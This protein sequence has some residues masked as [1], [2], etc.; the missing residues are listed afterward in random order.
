MNRTNTR[1]AIIG[2]GRAG[3]SL[4]TMIQTDP[5]QFGLTVVAVA[6]PDQ[7]SPGV[8]LARESGIELIVS[9][10]N[11]LFARDDIDLVVELTN[12]PT[13]RDEIFH[14][15]PQNTKFIDHYAARFF[16]DIYAVQQIS[17]QQMEERT[18][19]LRAKHNRLQNIL[20]SLPYEILVINKNYEVELANRTFLESNELT[21]NKVVGKY[22]YDVEHK[23]K[24]ECDISLG[25]CPHAETLKAGRSLSAVVN[26]INADGK[27][28]FTS[29][30]TAPIRNEDGDIESIIEVV[31]D[32]TP[33]MSIED[34]LRQTRARL[35][36]F[37]DT[38]PLF[39]YMKDTRL[40]FRVINQH[41]L[42]T[43]NLLENEVVGQT[44]LDI[45][46]DEKARWLHRLEHKVMNTGK[47][48]RAS[49]IL[50]VQGRLMHVSVTL[51][52][53]TQDE[54]N[55]GLFGMVEDTTELIE[56]ERKLLQKHEQ[57]SEQQRYLQG[58]LEN[59]RDL[60]FLSNTEGTLLSFNHSAEQTLGFQHDE[61]VD[62]PT[63]DLFADPEKFNALFT[64]ALDTGHSVGYEMEFS[65]KNGQQIVA[66]TSLTTIDDFGSNPIEVVCICRDVTTRL[67][68]KK[69]LVRSER[70]AAIGKMAAGVAHEINNP[71]AVISTITGVVEDTIA[72]EIGTLHPA[73]LDVLQKAVE[74]IHFQV[75]RCTSIT[76]S[77]LGFARKSESG[78]QKT[79]IDALVDEALN[80]LVSEINLGALEI[81]R[82]P[83][84]KLPAVVT[85]PMLVEQILINL[86]KNAI[87]AIDE[88][89]PA[90]GIIDIGLTVVEDQLELSIQDNGVGIPEDA[91]EK[92]FD[93]F[94]TSKPA[95]KGTGLGLA[96]VHDIVKR[97]GA[98]IKVDSEIGKWTCFTLILPLNETTQ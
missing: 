89:Q 31:K 6:D 81:R 12:N 19:H 46:P 40:R 79:N 64:E 87:D 52:P 74:R 1:I 53:V 76:H 50:P 39:I 23:T 34:T 67:R 38:A 58:V 25:G 20:D 45:F 84:T 65:L 44:G 96:I 24:P 91:Q 60:I 21:V 57:L 56:S 28:T 69:D 95:G 11:E 36:Q 33:R 70:L 48:M 22:C 75:K 77:L 73:T 54:K 9:D 93:L 51:F 62:Q 82:N 97:L 63:R 59:S 26:N 27:E 14:K 15:L 71:L 35:N 18:E 32:I 49:G 7:E 29:V 68:L 72:D 88:A 83:A 17:Q 92:I 8:I 37:I 42:R 61:V 41:A 85:D 16:W 80:L 86:L 10:Y 43:L 47:T 3:Y 4:L 5:K 13:I 90:R 66:N 78:L 98:Q 94:H 55:I 30:R 2:G